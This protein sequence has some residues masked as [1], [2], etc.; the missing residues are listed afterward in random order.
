MTITSIRYQPVEGGALGGHF[1]LHVSI[2]DGNVPGVSLSATELTKKI[3][4]SF[5]SLAIIS[6]ATK[7]VLLDCRGAMLREISDDMTSLIG[8]LRDWGFMVVLWVDEK[9]RYSWFEKANYITVFVTS[10]N[11]PNF[12]VN[13]IRY[14]PSNG[15]WIEPEV[16]PVNV[17]APGYVEASL[18][19]SPADILKFVTEAKRAWGV[20]ARYRS[21]P[22]ITFK[23]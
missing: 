8:T 20:V 1:A 23:V 18:D 9:T 3:H 6:E 22:S 11:W 14:V 2:G 15:S 12:R 10:A 19:H 13:E 16:Y 5:E 7:G 21:G 4:D 17:N